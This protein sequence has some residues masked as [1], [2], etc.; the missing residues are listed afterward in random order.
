M[1][2]LQNCYGWDD[3]KMFPCTCNFSCNKWHWVKSTCQPLFMSWQAWVFSD[4]GWLC[5]STVMVG[6]ELFPFPAVW[7]Y[8]TWVGQALKCICVRGLCSIL[9]YQAAWSCLTF[10]CYV[11]VIDYTF[12]G[13]GLMPSLVKMHPRCIISI[14]Q[15]FD[16]WAFTLRFISWN[17]DRTNR[18]LAGWSFSVPLI[19][20]DKLWRFVFRIFATTKSIFSTAMFFVTI[21]VYE[22]QSYGFQYLLCSHSYHFY[23]WQNF[24]WLI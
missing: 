10:V 9:P 13:C 14:A 15:K 19:M 17:L 7:C 12:L 23:G 3:H 21:W 16:L 11:N 24:W 5:H 6:I 18:S 8:H 1:G 20:H 2:F 4:L 22:Y